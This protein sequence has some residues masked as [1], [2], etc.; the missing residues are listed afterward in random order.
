MVE[1]LQ[2]FAL[3]GG[4]RINQYP[5]ESQEQYGLRRHLIF[6]QALRC[7]LAAH[8]EGLEAV[9]QLL[10][11]PN[12]ATRPTIRDQL[13]LWGLDP[14]NYD[15]DAVANRTAPLV[16]EPLLV[17]YFQFFG[18]NIE[19]LPL[20]ERRQHQAHPQQVEGSLQSFRHQA[21][22]RSFLLDHPEG[23]EDVLQH[24]EVDNPGL[25]PVIGRQLGAWGLNRLN[26]DVAGAVNRTTQM[27][28][29]LAA[30]LEQRGDQGVL[31]NQQIQPQ[32]GNNQEGP[33]QQYGDQ[34]GRVTIQQ[35]LIRFMLEH[36]EGLEDVVAFLEP[37]NPGLRENIGQFLASWG[38]NPL[39]YD[40]AGIVNSTAR[41]SG[42]LVGYVRQ[43]G[44]SL[45]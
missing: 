38:L 10:E 4:E 8:P 6:Q 41:P 17:G 31:L 27:T 2:Q 21:L 29:L 23:L 25:R 39:N 35:A 13:I 45:G 22:L 37:H 9:V 1:Y 12:P 19:P 30:Y 5:G 7:F 33:R 43:F 44:Y 26:Y 11:P 28:G 42:L 14:A 40:V 24:L 32:Q 3:V 15:I 16:A 20:S 18:L 36:P 34:G